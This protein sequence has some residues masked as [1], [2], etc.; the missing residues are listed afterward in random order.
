ITND[1]TTAI[2]GWS[3]NWSYTDG[4]RRTGGWN[5]NFSGNNPYTASG[6]GWNDRINPGQTVEFG[7]QGNKGAM[8]NPVQRPTVTGLVCGP[9][10][11][12]PRTSISSSSRSSSSSSRMTSS[13]SSFTTTSSSVRT[14]SSSSSVSSG[15]NTPPIAVLETTAHGLTVQANARDSRDTD[16]HTLQHTID[17]GDGT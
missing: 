11:S 1:S 8:N 4:F 3:V 6:V 14:T 2:N 10:S 9:T 12:L 13:S 16:G 17:F 5:A 7:I 15:P